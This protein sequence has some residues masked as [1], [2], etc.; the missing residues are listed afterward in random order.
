MRRA[1]TVRSVAVGAVLATAAGATA[2]AVVAPAA[3]SAAV[4]PGVTV[5]HTG[6]SP[7]VALRSARPL[8]AAADDGARVGVTPSWLIDLRLADVTK[9]GVKADSTL[10]PPRA[11]SSADGRYVAFNSAATNLG[12]GGND[13]ND[14][15]YLKDMLTGRLS[16]VSARPTGEV[17]RG[18]YPSISADGRLVAFQSDDPVLAGTASTAV[19]VKNVLTGALALVSRNAAG[20]I[21]DRSSF[22][23]QISGDG[24]VVVFSSDSDRLGAPNPDHV[25]QVWKKD[26][27]TGQLTLVSR[28]RSGGV[29][30]G[31]TDCAAP[32][33][34]GRFV[35]FYSVARNLIP[36]DTGGVLEVYVRDT[37]KR[38]TTLISAN[39]R[40]TRANRDSGE[41]FF[42][43]PD[44]SADGRL[45]SF[46]SF[47]TNL[48]PA[49]RDR[50]EDVYVKN[51]VTGAIRLASVNHAGIKSDRRSSQTSLSAGGAWL[52]FVSN[53]TNLSAE[54]GAGVTSVYLKDLTNGALRLVSV[55][56]AGVGG[57][58]NSQQ[59][60]LSADASTAVFLS[61]ATNLLPEDP[62]TI[63]DVYVKKLR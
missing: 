63:T 55:T 40:G 32:S 21:G 47:A 17:G 52:L 20:G 45:V 24:R 22:G 50:H 27:L 35:S 30:N 14:H 61:Q 25:S 33:R 26:V 54:A 19:Y 51:R 12:L 11:S 18:V 58:G 6:A 8:R 36:G 15:V 1:P 2:V 43:C 5:R 49:D 4:S 46:Q 37:A 7:F 48:S 34:N 9:S 57:N 62:D 10:N 31:Q 60:V 41:F 28:G 3:A 39:A 29:G 53:A 38:T 56:K 13:G 42:D 44:I 23:P 16:L 59:P